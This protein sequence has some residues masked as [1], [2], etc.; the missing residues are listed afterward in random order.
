MK[1]VI[2]IGIGGFAISKEATEFM[3]ARGNKIAEEELKIYNMSPYS[4][5]YGYGYT[6][7][8]KGGYDRTDSIL[9]QAVEELGDK[10]NYESLLKVVEIPDNIDWYIVEADDGSESIHERHRIWE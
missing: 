8:A 10:A 3:A 5:W 4:Q 9:I 2:N 7:I 6:S 1:V